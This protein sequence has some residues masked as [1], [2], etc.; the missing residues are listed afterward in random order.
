VNGTSSEIS[1]NRESAMKSSED[2]D[3][4]IP[5]DKGGIVWYIFF[6]WGIGVLLPWN[7]VL[8]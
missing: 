3:K 8:T 4:F 5:K 1:S 2:A 7:A 6:L